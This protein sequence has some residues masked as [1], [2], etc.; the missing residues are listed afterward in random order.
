MRQLTLRSHKDNIT[1][2]FFSSRR[3]HTRSLRDWSSDVCSSDLNDLADDEEPAV[4]ENFSG[5]VGKIDRAFDAVTKTELFCQPHGRVA[6]FNNP[7]SATDFIDNVAAIMLL[8]L[9]LHRGHHVRRTQVYFLARRRSA[10][11]EVRAHNVK[12]LT[13]HGCFSAGNSD[14]SLEP[15]A[16]WSTS[17]GPGGS[18]NQLGDIRSERGGSGSRL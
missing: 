11:D 12:S 8:D 17:R 14:H 16:Y 10:G 9:F 6:D 15:K 13:C 2:F 1:H 3:R 5:G 18:L 4:F 7:A